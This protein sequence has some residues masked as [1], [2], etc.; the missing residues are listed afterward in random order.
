MKRNVVEITN[1]LPA[2]IT[3]K[4]G[5]KHVT[6]PA[7]EYPADIVTGAYYIA[8]PDRAVVTG[9]P[10]PAPKVLYIVTWAVHE[11]RPDRTDLI[12]T[13]ENQSDAAKHDKGDST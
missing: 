3:I 11:A 1:L 10:G 13:S 12:V 8:H 7:A 2:P 5:R 4:V 6:L 9:L